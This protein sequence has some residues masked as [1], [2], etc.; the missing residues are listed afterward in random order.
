[1]PI[2][3]DLLCGEALGISSPFDE[4]TLAWQYRKS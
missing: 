2:L 1:V 4:A 3:E